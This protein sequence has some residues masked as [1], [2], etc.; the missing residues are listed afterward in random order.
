MVETQ[1]A[2]TNMASRPNRKSNMFTAAANV[3]LVKL[4]TY[5]ARMPPN[6]LTLR[7]LTPGTLNDAHRPIVLMTLAHTDGSFPITETSRRMNTPLNS[8]S[9]VTMTM[10]RLTRSIV[11]VGLCP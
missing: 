7:P 10:V 5:D 11:D 6:T 3:R 4:A 9:K 2:I 1:H 8:A